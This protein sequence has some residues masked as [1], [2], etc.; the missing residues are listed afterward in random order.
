MSSKEVD[1][2]ILFK[3]S[4]ELEKEWVNSSVVMFCLV[5]LQIAWMKAKLIVKR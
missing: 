1:V 2:F 5:I 3:Q 4:I